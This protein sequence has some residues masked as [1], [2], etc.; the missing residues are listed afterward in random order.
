MLSDEL[1][2]DRIFDMLGPMPSEFTELDT[3]LGT[4][5]LSRETS[6]KLQQLIGEIYLNAVEEAF[7]LGWRL[8]SD[9]TPL[10]FE[11]TQQLEG[12]P[13]KTWRCNL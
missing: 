6:F 9:P 3:L 7:A 11:E 12:F 4:L 13:R 1:V 10:L 5:N 8:R 2:S